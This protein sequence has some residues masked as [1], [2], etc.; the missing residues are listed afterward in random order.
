MY[1]KTTLLVLIV[2]LSLALVIPAAAAGP[3]F[4]PEV[5]GD[6]TAWG[7]KGTTSL[8]APNQNNLQS[9][10]KL[11]VIRNSNNPA[12]QLPVSEAAPGNPNYNGGRW[13]TYTVDWT[14]SGFAAH[15]TVPVLTSYADVMF[16]ESLG[17]LNI[18][19]GSFDG[20]P[21]PYFQCPLLPVK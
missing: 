3:S 19:Q 12:G 7:T 20:G 11:F 15:G 17:H 6:G 4:G 14:E 1:R 5:Y 16:H 18:V 9:F 2:L 10:D 8:P 21:P 13:I